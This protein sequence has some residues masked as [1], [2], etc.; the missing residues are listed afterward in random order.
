MCLRAMRAWPVCTWAVARRSG[1]APRL[2]WG[3][4]LWLCAFLEFCTFE[5]KAV[6]E[7]SCKKL[8]GV[9]GDRELPKAVMYG[10]VEDRWVK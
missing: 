10:G 8:A 6:G 3:G 4:W 7:R 2:M 1:E 9:E 5:T